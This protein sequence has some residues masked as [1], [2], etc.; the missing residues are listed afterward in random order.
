MKK[1]AGF[2]LIELLV[3]MAI[4]SILA[5][6]LLPVFAQ[7]R[8]AARKTQCVSNTRQLA[9]ALQM[10]AGDYDGLYPTHDPRQPDAT[11]AQGGLVVPEWSTTPLA[12]W[13]KSIQPYVRNY[14]VYTCPSN[15]GWAAGVVAGPRPISYVMNGFAAGRSQDGAPDPSSTCLLYDFRFLSDAARVNPAPGW[16]A[17][18][19]GWTAHDPQYVVLFQDSHAKTVHESSFGNQ[20]WYAPPG[21][22][23]Y[24]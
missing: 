14:P 9:L 7:A 10:Y 13:A 3:V 19:W 24:Y 17:W 1:R 21:N 2:T 4:I 20:I 22:M 6:I 23:F 8:E 5:G 18:Y 12:N 16:M 15:K 11:Y